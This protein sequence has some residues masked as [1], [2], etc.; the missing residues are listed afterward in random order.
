MQNMILRKRIGTIGGFFEQHAGELI[1]L[2]ILLLCY[3]IGY[4]TTFFIY[5]GS[6]ATTVA[7]LVDPWIVDFFT[8]DFKHVF[9]VS[10]GF[11]LSFS[12]FE[13]ISGLSLFG[14]VCI[15]LLMMLYGG[16]SAVMIGGIF[17]LFPGKNLVNR[18]MS[19]LPASSMFASVLILCGKHAALVSLNI[20]Q[21][22]VQKTV[23]PKPDLKRYFIN[24]GICLFAALAVAVLNSGTMRLFSLF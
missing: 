15:P 19:V 18:V 16:I 10:V 11:F 23:Q 7:A 2:S 22:Y 21:S 9:L 3:F 14:F 12:L 4:I 24:S 13:T 5:R 8:Y 6:I 1:P 17:L 20:Y